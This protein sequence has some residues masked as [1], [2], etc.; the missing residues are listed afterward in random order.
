MFSATVKGHYSEVLLMIA[1]VAIAALA[2]FIFLIK[3][4]LPNEKS[5][6]A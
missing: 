1:G 5:F 2:V 4:Q 3:G 6:S